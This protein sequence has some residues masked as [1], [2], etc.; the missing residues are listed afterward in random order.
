ML[1]TLR[2]HVGGLIKRA[3][4]LETIYGHTFSPGLLGNNPIVVDFGCNRGDFAAG[5]LG[6]FQ[7]QYRALDANPAM[8]AAAT[9][10][11]AVQ[12]EH[13]AIG[14]GDGTIEFFLSSNPEASSIYPGI[15]RAGYQASIQVPLLSY[16]SWVRK[17]GI[18]QVALL[19]I[20][21]EGAEL[22]LFEAW[23]GDVARPGQI[24]VEF[25]D[26]LDPSQRPRVRECIKRL[27]AHGYRYLNATRPDHVD[28]LFVDRSQLRGTRGLLLKTRWRVLDLFH[29]IRGW[30]RCVE[31]VYPVRA[32]SARP[33][34]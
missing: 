2:G 32:S 12:V 16:G 17:Q 27:Q 34:G 25:H 30:L 21:I 18:K 23:D 3:F 9:G 20:D 13:C 28:C 1:H 5:F 11:L 14:G 6:R 15:A 4:G 22:D 19:K 31:S 29:V 8:V 10:R 33:P 26:F 7:C 24:A